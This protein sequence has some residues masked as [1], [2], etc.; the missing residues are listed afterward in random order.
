MNDIF[1]GDLGKEL[2]IALQSLSPLLDIPFLIITFLGEELVFIAIL[3]AIFWSYSKKIGIKLF[4]L[5]VFSGILNS[6]MK[7]IFGIPRPY[8]TYPNEIIVVNEVSGY[9]FPSGHAMNSASFFGF[10][11]NLYRTNY[12]VIGLSTLMILLIS[13]SRIY[14]GVHYF[15]D[16]IFG[17]LFGLLLAILFVKFFPVL[18]SFFIKQTD[19]MNLTFVL[20]LSFTLMLMSTLLT[21]GFG[22]S[23]EIQSNGKLTGALAGGTIGILME[24][25]YIN[26]TTIKISSGTKIMRLFFGYFIVL[27]IYILGNAFFGDIEGNLVIMTDYV[28]YF[29]LAFG[30][31][32]IAPYVFN[33]FDSISE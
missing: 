1:L 9:S 33:K 26:F 32:F 18:E 22:N 30:A 13:I 6:L 24:K 15:S 14:L 5:M 27:T 3:G 8:Q 19:F 12:L 4:Y 16:I 10:I 25:R 29:V 20:L 31:V 28:R 11:A 21:V 23:L 2:I 7:G 17:I